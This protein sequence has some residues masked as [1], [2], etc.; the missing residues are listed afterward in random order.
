MKLLQSIRL[1][2]CLTLIT[3]GV[4]RGQAPL[5][6]APSDG[7]LV[8]YRLD[9]QQGRYL[10]SWSFDYSD[11]AKTSFVVISDTFSVQSSGPVCNVLMSNVYILTTTYRPAP[12]ND[13]VQTTFRIPGYTWSFPKSTKLVVD[14]SVVDL[15]NSKIEPPFGPNTKTYGRSGSS[16][17]PA[18]SDDQKIA[19]NSSSNIS[20]LTRRDFASGPNP[21]A[22]YDSVRDGEKAQAKFSGGDGSSIEK[23]VVITASSETTGYRAAYIWL[24]EHFPG[25]RLQREGFAYDDAGTYYTEITIVTADGKSRTVCFE[26]TSFF[27]K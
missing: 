9:G 12:S 26:T 22:D 13:V 19:Q 18:I 16:V 2:C 5:V 27:G 4:V 1:V 6:P 10:L 15:P 24:H 3:V 25:S 21:A 11:K 23:A 17:A 20:T 7:R 14:S 8:L